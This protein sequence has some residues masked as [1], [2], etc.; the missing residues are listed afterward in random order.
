MPL[1]MD[2]AFRQIL[3]ATQDEFAKV[4]VYNKWQPPDGTYSVLL[5]GFE[6]GVS[7]KGVA[8]G[9]LAGSLQAPGNAD[10]DQKE[11]SPGYY[12]T[13]YPISL[14]QDASALA[15]RK[16]NSNVEAFET[17]AKAADDNLMVLYTVNRGLTKKGKPF[18]GTQIDDIVPASAGEAQGDTTE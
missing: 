1:N 6:N 5:T 14:K 2:A 16:V 10:L 12:S 17:I 11:F 15:G 8:W 4:E 7:E 13:Q 3:A 18:V 9:R